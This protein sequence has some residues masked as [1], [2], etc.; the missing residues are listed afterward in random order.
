MRGNITRRGKASWR[1]KFEIEPDANG[2]RQYRLVT[3]RG[4]RKDAEREL[5]RLLGERDR[6]TLVDA[7]KVTVE[8]YLWGWLEGKHGLS[9]VS[10]ERYRE[11]IARGIV[12]M[13]GSIEL[14]KL[15]P[16]HVRGWLSGM[17]KH[18]S[19]GGGPLTAR[20]VRHSYRVLRAAL[21][22]AVKLDMLARNV[23]D[24]VTPPKVEA[25]EVEILDAEQI[26][27]LLDALKG[28]TLHSIASLALATGM[29]RGELL[30]LRWQDVNLDEA[31][32]KVERSLEQTKGGLRFKSPK[33]RHSRRTISLPPSAVAML[34]DHRKSQLELR[35][36]LGRGKHEPDALVFC[37]HEGSPISPNY[38]SIMWRRVISRNSGLPQVTFHALRHSHASAL[39]AGGIDVV[40]VSRRLGHSSPVITLSTYAH[41]F[42]KD[43]DGAAAAIEAVLG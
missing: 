8:A 5:T 18:G 40:K 21:Q 11:I 1:I 43:D 23:A 20:T 9:P 7:S 36:Q 32:L 10:V 15:K 26:A 27:A 29:R 6:G 34:R 38:F 24:A 42:S 17:V 3:V 37:D 22:D 31:S 41:L 13:L 28:R 33:T 19:R 39:I 16:A 2:N 30:A 35:M 4:L 12:P 25:A 14:Q